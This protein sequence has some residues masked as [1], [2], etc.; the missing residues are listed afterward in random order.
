MAEVAGLVLGAIPL[1]VLALD[2]Y[3]EPIGAL[4]RYRLSIETFRLT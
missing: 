1:L 3:A 2:R 4:H